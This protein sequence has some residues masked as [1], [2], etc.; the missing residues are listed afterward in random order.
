[1]PNRKS[2]NILLANKFKK[3]FKELLDNSNR[4]ENTIEKMM[5]GMRMEILRKIRSGKRNELG[6]ILQQIEE[7]INNKFIKAGQKIVDESIQL[8]RSESVF[9]TTS[10]NGTIGASI[11]VP[12]LN[13]QLITEAVSKAAIKNKTMVSFWKK[14]SEVMIN[15]F[16]KEFMKGFLQGETM[17]DLTERLQRNTTLNL[18][19]NNMRTIARTTLSTV[20][21][22]AHMDTYKSNSDVVGYIESMAVLNERTT[23]ISMA[24][25][26]CKWTLPDLV[27][28][29]ARQ[30]PYK[31]LALHLGERDRRIPGLRSYQELPEEK[32]KLIP[33]EKRASMDGLVTKPDDFDEFLKKR[34]DA[35]LKKMLGRTG[36]ELWKTGKITTNDLIDD[37]GNP[38]TQKQLKEKYAS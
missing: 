35:E 31:P 20:T 2:A 26:G 34:S 13:E 8:Y 25:N 9:V 12:I 1:M 11:T 36:A 33:P 16:R 5:L 14:Q 24:Y 32:K 21:D 23:F 18:A 37:L 30:L 10:I 27:P 7:I 3:H 22:S 4:V 17:N 19:K 6:I 15:G 29:G 28:F 38:L